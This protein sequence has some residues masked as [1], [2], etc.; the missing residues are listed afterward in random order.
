MAGDANAARLRTPARK[1][2][3]FAR[4]IHASSFMIS[5][6]FIQLERFTDVDIEGGF[7]ASNGIVDADI[8][9]LIPG[10]ENAQPHPRGGQRV[11]GTEIPE[12]ARDGADTGKCN[13]AET[14]PQRRA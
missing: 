13:G 4:F 12:V 14:P 6:A 1:R 11:F 3:A 7:I 10:C 8:Q 2:I 5:S 9:S